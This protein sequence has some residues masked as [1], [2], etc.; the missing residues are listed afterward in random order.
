MNRLPKQI[1]LFLL[2]SLKWGQ[3]NGVHI[4]PFSIS[5]DRNRMA[6]GV[7]YPSNRPNNIIPGV[8]YIFQRNEHG[9]ELE[10][11]FKAPNNSADSFFG[12]G[13]CISQCGNKLTIQSVNTG[14]ITKNIS[15]EYQYVRTEDDDLVMWELV[16]QYNI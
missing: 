4:S 7:C 3:N 6:V 11:T 13:L 2:N 8:V 10:H 12:F 9:W 14:D 1:K 15:M 5:A 16:G